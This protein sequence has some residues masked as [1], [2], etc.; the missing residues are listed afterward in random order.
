MRT[1][2]SRLIVAFLISTLLPLTATV[3][4]TMS[5]IDRSLGY[6]TTSEL[7]R[8][9]HTL[10]GTVRQLYQRERDALRREALEGAI[11]VTTFSHRTWRSGLCP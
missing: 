1:L 11:P 8:L 9:S 2:R 7:D 10:E 4:I 6:A 3:W 5:L